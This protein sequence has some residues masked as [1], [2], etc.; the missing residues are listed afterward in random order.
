MKKKTVFTIA[1]TIILT[2]TLFTNIGYATNET[3]YVIESNGVIV[4]DN[5]EEKTEFLL[6]AEWINSFTNPSHVD[7]YVSSHPWG[8]GIVLTDLS[9]GILSI[10][11]YNGWNPTKTWLGDNGGITYAQLKSVIDQFHIHNWKVVYSSGNVPTANDKYIYE[12]VTQKH[13]ELIAIA[14]NGKTYNQIHNDAI[15]INFF[16]KYTSPDIERNIT[17]G[18]RL[19]DLYSD[20][21]SKMI[22]DQAFQWDG[23]FGVDGWNGFTQQE[24]YW[25]KSTDQPYGRWIGTDSSSN[26]YFGDEQSI[27]EW[28]GSNFAKNLPQNWDSW[29]SPNK[30]ELIQTQYNLDWWNYW[31]ERFA[32][33]YG[34][35]NQVFDQRPPEF[36]VGNIISQDLSSSWASTNGNCL[37]GMENLEL[38]EKYNAFDHYY[39]DM[40]CSSDPSMAG[41][42]AA[43]VAGLVKSKMPSTHCI[44]GL[45]IQWNW[46]EVT[47]SWV[48]KQI[49]LAQAQSY[50]WYNGVKY[51]AVDVN[52]I[53]PFIPGDTVGYNG[54]NDTEF[55]GQEMAN[56]VK[57]MSKTLN[58]EIETLWLGPTEIIPLY[59]GLSGAFS[60]NYTFAQFTDALNLNNSANNFVADMKT[61]FLDAIR[62]YG[63]VIGGNAHQGMLELY[64]SGQLNVIYYTYGYNSAFFNTIF[65]G[66]DDEILLKAFNLKG[67][68]KT[69][70][71]SNNVKTLMSDQVTDPNGR[72]ILA[73]TFGINYYGL[74][75][76]GNMISGEG[77]IPLIEY[78]D[79]YLE[80]GISYNNIT[81]KFVY[82]KD[83]SA[84]NSG[85]N[86]SPIISRDVINRAI[87]WGSNCPIKSSEP[88]ADLK[89]FRLENSDIAITFM[90]LKNNEENLE[91]TIDLTELNFD[92]NFDYKAIWRASGSSIHIENINAVNITLVDGA[93]ILI[94]SKS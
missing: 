27:E 34:K 48:W 81:G 69:I 59:L 13:P 87:M 26:W 5:N 33:M 35:I 30:I 78:T 77:M 39:I 82:G 15:M 23:W 62:D 92:D 12:Y 46:G 21:L 73:D 8:T 4:R 60:F 37:V 44:I 16:A 57:L 90:N 3:T 50:V 2:L 67:G 76:V 29:S 55:N 83:W 71:T 17:I 47:P 80:L 7:E 56:W 61:I 24:M 20:R 1:T 84:H 58:N 25:L 65:I 28:A 93:D 14:G 70:G 91:I 22:S 18:Q 36:K 40:E 68:T 32:E 79:K 51:R 41:R 10:I 64:N 75:D 11:S 54:W 31:M 43:Y 52:W 94:V 63:T 72:Y 45:P 85:T 86:P 88:L 6:R 53:M 66:E 38:F 9:N 42:W 74:P 19:C 49:Y 89:I